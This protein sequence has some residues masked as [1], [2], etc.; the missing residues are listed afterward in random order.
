MTIG[1]L[2]FQGKCA[3]TTE[4]QEGVAF[5][6]TEAVVEAL[7]WELATTVVNA[8]MVP[9]ERQQ[10]PMAAKPKA[11]HR[12]A[13]PQLREACFKVSEVQPGVRCP[14]G[15][16]MITLGFKLPASHVIHIVGPIY[17][18]DNDPKGSLRNAYKSSMMFF[19]TIQVCR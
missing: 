16:A 3:S 2:R 5:E 17:D 1:S 15:E 13:G 6:I 12:A 7:K 11:I 4:A 9:A 18:S 19:S 8:P 14:T 10:Q